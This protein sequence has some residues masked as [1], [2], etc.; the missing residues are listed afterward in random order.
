MRDVDKRFRIYGEIGMQFVWHVRNRNFIENLEFFVN[1][2]CVKN[3]KKKTWEMMR[4][5]L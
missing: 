5:E 2:F 4:S 3:A 1:R